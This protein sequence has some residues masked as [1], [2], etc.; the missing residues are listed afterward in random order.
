MSRQ[1]FEMVAHTSD[2]G[3]CIH[4]G[5]MDELLV[6]A[7]HALYSIMLRTSG[8]EERLERVVAVD[9]PDAETLLIDWLNELIYLFDAERLA[10]SRFD[11]EQLSECRLEIRCFGESIDTSRHRVAREVKAA[12]Y[13]AAH[14][15]RTR[16]R[17]SAHVILDV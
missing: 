9:S 14:I 2:I 10:F 8:L 1:P 13:H 7:A 3:V 5:S 11:V 16:G 6:N 4:G 12:T 15:Y 17:Y